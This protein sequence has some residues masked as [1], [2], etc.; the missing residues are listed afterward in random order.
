MTKDATEKFEEGII[1]ERT[2][3]LIIAGTRLEQ[4]EI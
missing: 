1:S 4:G 3:K 2:Y